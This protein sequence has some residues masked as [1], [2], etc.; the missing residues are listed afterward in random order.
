M[1]TL[2]PRH[3][4]LIDL[5]RQRW[6]RMALA[7]LCMLLMATAS[8][9]IPFLIKNV[10]DDIFVQRNAEM[11]R[12]LPLVVILIYTVLGTSMYGQEYLMSYVG[13]DIVRHLRD[14]LYARIQAMPI[15]FFHAHQTG[16]LMSRV[17]NDVN[18]IRNMVSS[19]ITGSLRDV[20]TIV[21]LICVIFYRDWKMALA[22]LV[23]LPVAYFPIVALGRRV[24]RATGGGQEAFAEM[25]T[26]LHETFAGNKIVKAFGQEEFEK[27]R[28][29]AKT[30]RLFRLEMKAVRYKALTSPVMESLAGVGVAFVIWYGGSKVISGAST[31][32][33]FFSF[34]AAVLMLYG[35]VKKLSKLNSKVQAGLV[36]VDRVF[37]ILE[38]ETVIPEAEK[39][40]PLPRRPHSVIF[41]KVSFRYESELVLEEIDV[42]AAPGENLALVG[43]SGGGKTSLVNL[44][45]RFYDVCA[46]AVRID[47]LDVRDLSLAELRSQIAIVTQEPILFNESVRDNIAYG[48]RSASEIEIIDAA[49][50]AFAHDFI[51]NFPQGMDTRIGELGSRLSGGEKQRICIARALLKD[52]PIL[53]L[54]EATS[55]LD[56]QAETLVQKA[57]ENLMRGRTT[58]IIAHRLSTID[59]ADRILVLKQGRIVEQGTQQELLAKGGIYR[60]LHDMQFK[61]NASDRQRPAQPI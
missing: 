15:A 35:P 56:A 53:I 5:V 2:K 49:K 6:W 8:A 46:G 44:I 23:I 10:V 20:F 11:L 43:M 42:A 21:G 12:L 55:A 37:D 14:R 24:R 16:V 33:T 26:Q 40:K 34:M 47:D 38:A 31:A 61:P 30:G 58:F 22:A 28:F 13:Q 59:F 4:Y 27:E 25:N 36:G 3:L 50:A 1:L 29:I 19:A 18:I 57:L 48:N 51:M 39:P 60:D 45:P 7:M 52:A 17:T 54:D 32:G 41:E 9:A